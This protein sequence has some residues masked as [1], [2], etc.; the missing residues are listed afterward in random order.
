MNPLRSRSITKAN[1]TSSHETD[2]NDEEFDH[3]NDENISDD[4]ENED[5]SDSENDQQDINVP[6]TTTTTVEILQAQ[7]EKL[8]KAKQKQEHFSQ[9]KMNFR[10]LLKLSSIKKSKLYR[11]RISTILRY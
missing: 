11:E 2:K 3:D 9:T 6:K 8:T 10:R 1:D 5:I 7:Y 4:S